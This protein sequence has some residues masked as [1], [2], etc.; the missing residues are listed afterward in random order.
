MLG[1]VLLTTLGLLGPASTPLQANP[2]TIDIRDYGLVP[3]TAMNTAVA[4][5]QAIFGGANVAVR[6]A[7]QRRP[8]GA[9]EA[10]ARDLSSVTVLVYPRGRD[11]RVVPAPEVLGTVPGATAGGR[12]AY[13]FAARIEDQARRYETDYGALLGTILAHEVGH[14]LLRGRPHAA[15]GLMRAVCDARQIRGV[16][17]GTTEFT[18]EEAILIRRGLF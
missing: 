18:P 2:L 12:I 7:V 5:L 16:M 10:A 3:R 9:R 4:R 15:T 1:I 17:L 6:I 13:V 11:D 8:V 14:V